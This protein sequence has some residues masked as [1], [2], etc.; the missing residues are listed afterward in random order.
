MTEQQIIDLGFFK[1]EIPPEESGDEYYY[2]Y[3]YEF[4]N[5]GLCLVTPAH[6]NVD[7]DWWVEP[8]NYE[9][10]RIHDYD[11]LVQL[12]ETVNTILIANK[13]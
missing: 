13:K 12:M 4:G 5:T 3:E 9:G 1:I 10:L 2:F 8:F 7:N 11:L 6:D